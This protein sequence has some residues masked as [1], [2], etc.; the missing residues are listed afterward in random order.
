MVIIDE[1]KLKTAH[2]RLKWAR[3][4]IAHFDSA[5]EA[6]I[7]LEVKEPTYLAHENGSRG[8]ARSGARYARRFGI[9]LEWLLTGRGE[10]KSPSVNRRGNKTRP[11]PRI[12][13]VSQDQEGVEE[14]TRPAM[15]VHSGGRFNV[16]KGEIPQIAARLGL[17]NASDADTIQIPIGDGSVMAVP[18]ITTWKVPESVLRRHLHGS[19]NDVHIVECIGDSMEPAIHNGDFVF[20][21]TGARIPHPSG[22]FAIS[23][24]L[25]PSLKRIEVVEN[26]DPLRVKIIPENQRHST[27][28]SLL[29]EV[30]IIGRYLCRLTMAL[31]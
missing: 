4:N 2:E 12:V 31:D 23:E 26:S 1:M 9:S 8:L 16:P 7:A 28:E 14:S 17:G 6:A 11:P 13:S 20:I 19:I 10:P 21:D 24:T 22:I 15:A 29:E 18:V 5:T 30:T 3:E 25:G 27:Y